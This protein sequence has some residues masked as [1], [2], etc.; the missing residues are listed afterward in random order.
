MTDGHFMIKRTKHL[1]KSQ[2]EQQIIDAADQVL[3]G[4]GAQN[5]TIDKMVAH[6]DVAKGTVYKY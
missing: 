6:L 4:V 3:L 5:L 1:P 2:R